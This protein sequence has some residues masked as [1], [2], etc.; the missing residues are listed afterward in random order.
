M[1]GAGA[2][3]AR[4][5]PLV[6]IVTPCLNSAPFLEQTILSVLGQDYP[7]IEY[8]VM[9]GGSRDGTLDILRKYEAEA[10]LRWHS[11][12]DHGQADAVN[13]GFLRSS[14]EIF[15]F[16]NADDLLLP[17]AVREAVRA[18][19][20]HPEVA[21]VY[22]EARY[23][24]ASGAT[25]GRYEIEDFDAARLAT[26]CYICQPAAFLRREAFAGAGMLDSGLD[27]A[28]DYDLWIRLARAGKLLRIG[29]FL[30]AARMHP[31]AKTL[32]ARRDVYREAALVVGRHFGYVPFCY[33]YGWACARLDPRD[34]FFEPVP[35]SLAKYFL[36]L[37]WGTTRNRWRPF[38][39]WKEWWLAGQDAL[40]RGAWPPRVRREPKP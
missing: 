27:F 37:G 10:R 8:L 16:L 14:G 22:G 21:C 31:G 32:R 12:P 30:A 4:A 40:R 2:M 18:L 28:L 6:S 5:L 39:F 33:A 3:E 23:V 11:E 34:G 25:L 35:P 15:A 19:A 1:S 13:R 17:G 36:A 7:R 24:D 9:D 26:R 38:R 20:E 29:E